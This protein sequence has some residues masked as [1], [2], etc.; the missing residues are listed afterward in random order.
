MGMAVRRALGGRRRRAGG[1]LEHPITH[2]ITPS[3][4]SLA[5]QPAH[6]QVD[7]GKNE[8]CFVAA[9]RGVG[10]PG[11]QQGRQV[12]RPLEQVELRL[13]G[14]GRHGRSEGEGAAWGAE[15]EERVR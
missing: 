8:D 4:I 9:P 12:A 15:R 11:A 2:P 14:E 6:Q 10:E 3:I 7:E 13:I 1:A 5:G